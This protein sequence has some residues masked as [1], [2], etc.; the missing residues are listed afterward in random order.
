MGVDKA[1]MIVYYI[2]NR[3]DQMNKLTNFKTKI[4]NNRE[5]NVSHV[6]FSIVD[7]NYKTLMVCKGRNVWYNRPWEKYTYESALVDLLRK[8]KASP[9]NI[10]YVQDV[11]NNIGHSFEYLEEH[12]EIQVP[13]HTDQFI[14][15]K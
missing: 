6:S 4:N 10:A 5:S 7:E 8:I 9:A 12:L 2:N 15:Y 3:R 13:Y 14:S 1:P 11:S